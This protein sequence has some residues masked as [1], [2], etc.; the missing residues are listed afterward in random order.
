M[1]MTTPTNEERLFIGVFPAGIVYAD[2]HNEVAGDYKRLG[3]LSFATLKLDVERSC[4]ADLRKR[5]ELDAAATQA[6]RGQTMTVSTCG[7]TVML[8]SRLPA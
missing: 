1:S 6:K 2:R 3:F 4:P 5:I 8:G 7:Q